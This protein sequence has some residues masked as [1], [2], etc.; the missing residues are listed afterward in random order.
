MQ[1]LKFGIQEYVKIL[2]SSQ[3]KLVEKT[4][5]K[6]GAVS[7][8]LPS[9]WPGIAQFGLL[10]DFSNTHI[11]P[12]YI[13][14]LRALLYPVGVVKQYGW[15]RLVLACAG[16]PC[17]IEGALENGI[18][19]EVQVAAPRWVVKRGFQWVQP[20]PERWNANGYKDPNPKPIEVFPGKTILTLH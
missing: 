7:V 19:E 2:E 15:A 8:E 12:R 6:D 4:L 18:P 14:L 16:R 5:G 11:P 13:T 20:A 17:G 10:L 1:L 3:K 9:D